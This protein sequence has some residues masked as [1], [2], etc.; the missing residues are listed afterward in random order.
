MKHTGKM[1]LIYLKLC[2][3][4]IPSKID[5]KRKSASEH[6]K[7]IIAKSRKIKEVKVELIVRTSHALAAQLM[8]SNEKNIG[9]LEIYYEQCLNELHHVDQLSKILSVEID[10]KPMWFTQC[11]NLNIPILFKNIKRVGFLGHIWNGNEHSEKGIQQVKNDFAN[12]KGKF[13]GNL[14]EK[15]YSNKI[16]GYLINEE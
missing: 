2:N 1:C 11:N 4:P 15:L 14:M 9:N 5:E 16:M 3:K 8:A 10:K 12:T 6:K 13:A 7:S